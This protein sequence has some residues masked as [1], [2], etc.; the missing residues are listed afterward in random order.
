MAEFVRCCKRAGSYD[1]Y[2]AQ[3]DKYF[4]PKSEWILLLCLLDD[5]SNLLISLNPSKD[6]VQDLIS[7]LTLLGVLY[8]S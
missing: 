6:I 7:V 1:W 4:R 3:E 2:K 8:I 5:Y